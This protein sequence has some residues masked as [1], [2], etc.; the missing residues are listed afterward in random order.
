MSYVPRQVVQGVQ[1]LLYPDGPYIEVAE[2]IRILHKLGKDFCLQRA[3][4]LLVRNL[5]IYRVVLTVDGHQYIGDA[6]IHFGAPKETPDGTNP[7]TCGQTSAIGDALSFA[8]YGDLRLLLERQKLNA[9]EGKAL[10]PIEPPSGEIEGIRVVWLDETPYVPVAERLYH[11]YKLSHT[12]SIDHCEVVRIHGVWVYRVSLL[13]DEHR[14]IADAEVNFAAPEIASEQRFPVSTAQTSAVGNALALAGFGDVR[15][16]LERMGKE[17]EQ[18]LW[19]PSLA[20]ADAVSQAQRQRQANGNKP[21]ATSSQDD[22][23]A[24]ITTQQK[25]TIRELSTKLGEPEPIVDD[26]TFAEAETYIEVLRIQ[27]DDL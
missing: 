19:I 14:Y 10:Y 22:A 25:E 3:E 11:L 17:T 8:G 6:E 1:T 12:L 21:Q 15:S 23:P 27:V 13:V 7:V 24:M 18:G 5:W 4:T 2:R 9:E 26:W 20:S 16:L